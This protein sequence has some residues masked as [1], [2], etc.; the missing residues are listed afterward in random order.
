MN[1]CFLKPTE[2]MHHREP[3]R[4]VHAILNNKACAKGRTDSSLCHF[5]LEIAKE[6]QL[7]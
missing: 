3:H 1:R 7:K 4:N 5:C 6:C 2:D